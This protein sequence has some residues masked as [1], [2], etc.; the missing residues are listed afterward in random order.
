MNTWAHFL[1]NFVRNKSSECIA[2]SANRLRVGT[3]TG[4]ELVSLEGKSKMSR[5][6]ASVSI[7]RLAIC[8]VFGA[9]ASVSWAQNPM[10]SKQNPMGQYQF[11]KNQERPAKRKTLSLTD[12]IRLAEQRNGTI[13]AAIANYHASI[14]QRIE[15][16]ASF[17]PKVTPSYQYNSDRQTF[18]N[19]GI[20]SAGQS[21]G[22]NSQI[23]ASW[24]LLDTGQREDNFLSARR[25]EDAQ[26]YNSLQTLR[27]TVFNVQQQ[28]Y[29]T[30]RA[31][32][33][34][35]VAN[36]QVQRTKTI[37]TQT[38]DSVAVG[39]TAKIAT[40]QATADYENA[41]VTALQSENAV[42]T[43]EATLKSLIGYPA[44]EKLPA[45]VKVAEPDITNSFPSLAAFLKEGIKN[46][47]D[48]KS[49][50]LQVEALGYSK[51]YLEKQAGIT[52][53]LNASYTQTITPYPLQNRLLTLLV[54]YPLFDGGQSRAAVRAAKDDQISAEKTYQQ[55]ARS[56][57]SEIE[58]AYLT[59]EQDV[60]QVTAANVALTAAQANYNQTV[61][62][63][64]LGSST[65]IDVLT[66]Q[67]SLVTAESNYIQ[68]EYN[69][70]EAELSLRL[71]TGRP[72]Y[73]S[74]LT[75]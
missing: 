58:S 43:N 30:L 54:S 71:A 11:P 1:K 75:S 13:A 25:N 31:E 42:T 72:L 21:E 12:A 24:E 40:L 20:Y 67:V 47:P 66:A 53:S 16:F 27:Q 62:S 41:K 61:Q 32:E 74:P 18:R 7:V 4:L 57:R 5:N 36:S 64:A 17:L 35:K 22:G 44:D 55:S 48:L 38:K 59:V 15:S 29:E 8:V 23:T 10:K 3:G 45:L 50:R 2:S 63:Q 70:D 34:L 9:L 69:F 14:E 49:S 33:L 52:A 68:A 56:A 37:L 65:L 28:Y 51:D 39:Q 73:G 60:S 19:S 46:R 6:A 26:Y